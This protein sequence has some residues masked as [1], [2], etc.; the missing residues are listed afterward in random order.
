MNPR[1][2]VPVYPCVSY[3]LTYRSKVLT[4]GNENKF[5]FI[6]HFSRLIVP[7]HAERKIECY[8]LYSREGGDPDRGT[9]L[10]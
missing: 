9:P 10:W 5:G 4:L 6:L 8:D 7:L 2:R 3:P 1:T